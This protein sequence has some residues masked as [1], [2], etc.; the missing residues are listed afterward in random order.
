MNHISNQEIVLRKVIVEIVREAEWPLL[1]HLVETLRNE[2]IVEYFNLHKSPTTKWVTIV[3]QK[4]L[5]SPKG[6]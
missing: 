5:V 1:P 2:S 4:F 3:E 6:K